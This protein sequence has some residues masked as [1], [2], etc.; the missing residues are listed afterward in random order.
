MDVSQFYADQVPREAAGKTTLFEGF[1]L[2]NEVEVTLDGYRGFHVRA[3]VRLH[4]RRYELD[5]LHVTRLDDGREITGAALRE[6]TPPFLVRRVL[7][8]HREP[9]WG[10]SALGLFLPE[11]VE[12]AKAEGPTQNTIRMAAMVYLAAAAVQD[13]PARAVREVFAVSPR[14]AG[15]WIAKAKAAGFI[16]EDDDAADPDEEG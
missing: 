10:T 15:N 1:D 11:E 6:I 13:P 5:E 8:T 16:P 2:W 4:H 9:L 12:A 3:V 14:T 7:R